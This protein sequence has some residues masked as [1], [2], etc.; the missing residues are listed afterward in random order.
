MLLDSQKILRSVKRGKY[1]LALMLLGLVLRLI[2]INSRSIWFDE[3]ASLFIAKLPFFQIFPGL[4]SMDFLPPLYYL[5]LHVWMLVS[6]SQIFLELF[7]VLFSLLSIIAIYKLGSLLYNR[8]VGHIAAF[9]MAVACLQIRYSQ[10]IRMYTLAVFLTI[11]SSYYFMKTIKEE[12]KS[13]LSIDWVL[14]VLTSAAA[15]Y[16]HYYAIFVLFAQAI[17]FIFCYKHWSLTKKWMLSQAVIATAFLPW[18]PALWLQVQ[19]MQEDYWITQPTL[20]RIFDVVVFMMDNIWNFF[21]LGILILGGIV[22]FYKIRQKKIIIR[23][24]KANYFLLITILAPLLVSLLI[25]LAT[26]SVFYERY[27]IL[28]TPAVYLLAA[29]GFSHITNKII[30]GIFAVAY[31]VANLFCLVP[32]YASA[33]TDI[34]DAAEFVEKEVQE[35]DI[36]VHVDPFAL[37]SFTLYHDGRIK[38]LILSNKKLPIYLGGNYYD[39]STY[40]KNIGELEQYKRIWFVDRGAALNEK[41]VLAMH[42]RGTLVQ[43]ENIG[44]VKMVVYAMEGAV[45]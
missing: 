29:K 5:L 26:Q 2:T 4:A 19:H 45:S 40:I 11:L 32:Y 43:E 9:L 24:E 14:Y 28:F 15:L 16:T 20:L 17:F 37:L 33:N 25:S 41:V 10:E 27:F 13:I 44:E 1:V 30:A 38:N 42:G 22:S 39:E 34:A 3:A 8:R 23:K 12:Q 6:D 31:I 18:I 7:S 21:V 35:G 36:V